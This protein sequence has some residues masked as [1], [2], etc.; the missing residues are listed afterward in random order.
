[1]DALSLPLVLALS[2][3]PATTRDPGSQAAVAVSVP[4]ADVFGGAGVTA[5]DLAA[6]R[7]WTSPDNGLPSGVTCWA[8]LTEGPLSPTARGFAVGLEWGVSGVTSGA[9][10]ARAISSGAGW[11]VGTGTAFAEGSIVGAE[12]RLVPQSGAANTMGITAHVLDPR[13][14]WLPM[15][16]AGPNGTWTA[17]SVAW[18]TFSVSCGWTGPVGSP[19][20][21]ARVEGALV[22][23]PLSTFPATFREPSIPT[24]RR[25]WALVGQSNAGDGPLQSGTDPVWG[26]QPVQAGATVV[27]N[28]AVITTYPKRP[29]LVPYLVQRLLDDGVVDPVVIVRSIGGQAISPFMLDQRLPQAV[30]DAHRLGLQV[31]VLAYAQGET[32]CQTAA[33]AAAYQDRLALLLGRAEGWWHAPM[34]VAECGPTC[35][36]YG[37]ESTLRAG[38]AAAVA[39]QLGAVLVDTDGLAVDATLHHYTQGVSGGYAGLADRMVGAVP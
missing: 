25:V 15:Q 33:N 39:G 32:D 19:S 30:A 24:G 22:A 8:S 38:Q 21:V 12:G 20:A 3:V 14:V 13:G 9:R 31:E 17:T 36:G 11:T 2:S 23:V 26:L 29:A 5:D 27:L 7:L 4:A 1:M 28:G 18:D 10:A 34:L 37:Y 16:N 6:L 35:D